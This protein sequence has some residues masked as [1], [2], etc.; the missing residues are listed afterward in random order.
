M[1]AEGRWFNSPSL[2]QSFA[3]FSDTSFHNQPTCPFQ[4]WFQNR[5]A[6]YRKQ[7]KLVRPKTEPKEDDGTGGIQVSL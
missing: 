6:K 4:V 7:E 2:D 1:D 5:R 3:C